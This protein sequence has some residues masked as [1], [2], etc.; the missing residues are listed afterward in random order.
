MAKHTRKWTTAATVLTLG[1]ILT[2]SASSPSVAEAQERS[3]SSRQAG[4]SAVESNSFGIALIRSQRSRRLPQG[5]N[6]NPYD[7]GDY[8]DD[9]YPYS[10]RDYGYPRRSPYPRYSPSKRGVF[11]PTPDLPRGAE[12]VIE[13]MINLFQKNR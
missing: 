9:R 2:L 7:E 8:D 4:L 13:G 12:K 11:I 6:Y 3:Y 1:F 10:D 5:S